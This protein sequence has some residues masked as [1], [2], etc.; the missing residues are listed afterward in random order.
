MIWLGVATVYAGT[1]VNFPNVG[2]HP[3]PP[4]LLGY[5]ARPDDPGPFPAVIVLHGCNG[6]SAA[7]AAIADDLKSLGYVA[8]TVDSLGPRNSTGECGRF[9]VG[10]ELDA[11]TA[12]AYLSLLPYVDP[13]RVAVL[14]NSMGGYSALLAVQRGALEKRFDRKFRAAIAYYP[15]CR[16]FSAIMT[17]PTMI[18]IGDADDWT[19]AEACR[20]MIAQPHTDGAK[21]DLVIY[22]GAYH[23]FN[24]P[25]LQPGIR[26]LGHWLEYDKHAATDAW[27]KVSTFLAT[28]LARSP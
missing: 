11:Y 16:G 3:Y 23:G 5:L 26:V 4:Q 15:S 17:A 8:L 2:E 1:L 10:Q 27:D 7:S 6:F 18:L 28:N 9:F 12:L 14:G 20:K 25:Q 24:F 22:P 13:N 21:I 19:P